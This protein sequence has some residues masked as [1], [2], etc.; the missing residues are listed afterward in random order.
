[1]K[2]RIIPGINNSDSD[3]WQSL[4]EL[5][6]GFVR[7]QQSE[8]SS[9]HYSDWETNL[10]HTIE[11]DNDKENI[12]VAH[13]LGCLLTVK[14]LSKIRQYV[15]GILLV[16]PPDPKGSYF[17]KNVDS[18]HEFPKDILGIPGI[19]AYSEN[20]EYSSP[21]FSR[22]IGEQWGIEVVS[23]GRVGHINSQSDIGYWDKGYSLLEQLLNTIDFKES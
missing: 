18:F 8:W 14:A 3:H 20:D 12:L 6:Y 22:K 19:L 21:E 1:M 13:S 17:P 4:W 5:K 2:I 15:K 16:A 7:V 10:I 23:V 9:P 11:S